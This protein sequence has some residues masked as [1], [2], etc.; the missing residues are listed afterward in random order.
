MSRLRGR[1][2]Y[3]GNA[4]GDHDNLLRV[5]NG[6]HHTAGPNVEAQQC[7][8]RPKTE[9]RC[10][11]KKVDKILET[12]SQGRQDDAKEGHT[13]WLNAPTHCP[14]PDTKAISWRRPQTRHT[15]KDNGG[16]T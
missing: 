11:L 16:R 10:P 13:F 9:H 8:K 12:R 15:H 7:P 3:D 14:I 1:P 2:R 4:Q 5:Q 6:G